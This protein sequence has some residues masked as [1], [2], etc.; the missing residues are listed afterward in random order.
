MLFMFMLVAAAAATT[1]L[2]RRSSW[3]QRARIGMAIAMMVAGASHLVKPGTFVQHLPDSVPGRHAFGAISGVIEIGLGAALL[4]SRPAHQKTGHLLA[5][6]LVAIFPANV[7]AAAT[8][9][10][11]DEQPDRIY[12]WGRLPLHAIFIAWTL[13]STHPTRPPAL[14]T[15]GGNSPLAWRTET[16]L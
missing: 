3:R 15:S 12:A 13:W 4:R 16:R 14:R 7:Y 6:Y 10:E 5:G 8:A 2:R 1:A 9:V 11:M